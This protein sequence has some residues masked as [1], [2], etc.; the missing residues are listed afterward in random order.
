MRIHP[1]FGRAQPPRQ[2]A[3]VVGVLAAGAPVGRNGVQPQ[4]GG[5]DAPAIQATE[6]L[7]P[8]VSAAR[9]TQSTSL[10]G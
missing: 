3:Q 9:R 6:S 4:T 10:S 7:S 2:V 8:L 1:S 5:A